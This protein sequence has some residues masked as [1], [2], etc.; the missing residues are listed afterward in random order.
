M[1]GLIP[2]KITAGVTLD[3]TV[4]VL[5]YPAPDWS[6]DLILRGPAGIDLPSIDDGASHRFSVS[7]ATTAD[8]VPGR[9]WWSLRA[10]M[11]AEVVL[12]D[13]GQLTIVADL[14]Q[15][16]GAFDNRSH[17]EKVLAAVEA[18]IEGRATLDQESY[19]IAGRSLS[20][21]PIAEL[22]RLRL[23]YRGEVQRERA[24]ARG[25]GLIGRQVKVR[26]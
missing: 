12:I 18:V 3:L 19:T 23:F 5:A 24:A 17:A 16:D 4:P 15:V 25:Q 6:L 2:E 14:A 1:A 10:V 8:W 9:Y 20:R 13:E 22:Q 7:A 26:F 11:G 21:T